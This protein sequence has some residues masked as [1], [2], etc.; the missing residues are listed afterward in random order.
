LWCKNQTK[1]QQSWDP[2]PHHFGKL[3]PDPHQSRKLDPGPHPDQSEKQ[4][5]DPDADLHQSEKVA[6]LEGHL[7]L[8]SIGGS[9]SKK[10]DWYVPS[11]S[12]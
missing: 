6:A 1:K 7:G 2:D 3:D 11:G 5:P 12:A 10:S 8:G 9:K 4:D